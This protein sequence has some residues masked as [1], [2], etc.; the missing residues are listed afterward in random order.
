[1][2]PTAEPA[3]ASERDPVRILLLEDDAIAADMLRTYLA[4]VGW[5]PSQLEWVRTLDEGL[6]RLAP[7]GFDL[8]ITDLGLPDSPGGMATLEELKRATDRVIVVVSGSSEPGVR[9][10]ALA[11]GAYDFLSKDQLD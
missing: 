2:R 11:R 9:E 10:A 7:G 8:V 6:A 5:A 3:N 4:A 1:M